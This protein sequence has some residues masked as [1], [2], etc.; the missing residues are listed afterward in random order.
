MPF[1]SPDRFH[2]D[3]KQKGKTFFAGRRVL[4]FVEKNTDKAGFIWTDGIICPDMDTQKGLSFEAP[5]R[6]SDN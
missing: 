4:F 2:V 6:V 1:L 5:F 3:F